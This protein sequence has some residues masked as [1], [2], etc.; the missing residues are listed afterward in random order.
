MKE[1]TLIA[2]ILLCLVL[3]CTQKKD[4]IQTDVGDVAAQPAARVDRSGQ[5]TK[6]TSND[7]RRELQETAEKVWKARVARDCETIA[8][9]YDPNEYAA[10]TQDERLEICQK[11]P[12]RYQSYR[13]GK[14]EAEI[15]YGWIYVHYDAKFAPYE[16]E[17]AE[18]VDTVE[19]WK[20]IRDVWYP[21]PAR[22]VETC[23]ESPSQRNA[24]EEA[25]LRKRFERT[26]EL[27]L[28]RDWKSLYEMTDPEDR[29]HVSESQ[30]AES[31]GLIQYFGH[32]LEW[33][34][35]MGDLGQIRVTYDNKLNDPNMSKM[36]GRKINLAEHWIKRNGEWYRDLLRN[37]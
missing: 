23:P 18:S 3:S 27:R 19:K 29:Q 37:K 32:D 7:A 9:Y 10:N 6:T 12:F 20:R 4:V 2:V 35:V 30:Y 26:W 11:D 33:V 5:Q 1:F 28:A 31:E 25:K 36:R 16:A 34:E 8:K 22:I 21:V 13:I 24:A 15:P 14:V 17:P